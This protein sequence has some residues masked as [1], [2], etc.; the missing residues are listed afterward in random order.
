[1]AA[2][3]LT[4]ARLTCAYRDAVV[5]RDVS[6]DV[7]QGVVMGVIGPNGAGKSTLLKAAVGLI[8]P[9]AGR[10]EFLGRPLAEVRQQVGYMRQSSSVDWDFP[11]TVQDVVLMGTYGRLGWLRRPG[12]PERLAAMD[13]L[14]RVGIAELAERPIGQLSGGERQRTFLARILAQRPDVFLLDEPFAGV[15]AASQTA[16]G[17]VLHDLRD[18]G[19]TVVVVHHDLATVPDLCDWVTLINRRVVSS[20]PTETAFTERCI[21]RAYGL[22]AA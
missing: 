19:R 7:P 9:V 11:T 2:A 4:V 21:K 6:L 22:V 1:M 15:D 20:G 10:V 5:L 3:A 14:D 12:R 17:Q 8:K 13:A 18:E 16:I